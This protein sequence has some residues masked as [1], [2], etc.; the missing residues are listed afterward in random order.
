MMHLLKYTNLSF[1]IPGMIGKHHLSIR[2]ATAL[3]TC[4][5]LHL[6]LSPTASA[7]V[8]EKPI[9]RI[10]VGQHTAMIN[11]LAV[12]RA[13][14]LLA[15][16]SDDKTVRLWN[17]PEG[18]LYTT[19]RV[20][21]GDD[22]K[23]ALYAAAVSPDGKTVITAGETIDADQKFSLYVFDV[24]KRVLKARIPGL[25]SAIYHLAYSKDGKYFAAA[26]AGG[27]GI[28][29][30]DSQTGK[31]VGKDTDY[32][33]RSN[34]LAFS[35]S[36][37]LASVSHDGYLRLYD[38][39]F[40]LLKKSRLNPNGLPSSVAF[41]ANGQR[42]A[43][44]YSNLL[45]VD[46]IDLNLNQQASLVSD[47]LLGSNSAI[48]A[49]EHGSDTEL[50]AAGDMKTTA[51]RFVIRHWK[52]IDSGHPTKQDIEAGSNIVTDMVSLPQNDEQALTLFAS[53][54]PA[55]GILKQD[56]VMES[57]RAKLWD[58]RLLGLPEK[59]FLL[60]EDG[61]QV[62]YSQQV[63]SEQ[64]SLFDLH[65]LALQ[66]PTDKA[67]TQSLKPAKS[68]AT[69]IT[70]KNWRLDVPVVNGKPV[71]LD[72][73]EKS[74]SLAINPVDDSALI[75][76][77]YYLRWFDPAG[78]ALRK[79]TMPAAVNALS[80]SQNGKLAVAALGDGTI[81]WYSL[82]P[83]EE[84][85]ELV[86]FF[87]Y[88]DGKEWIVWTPEG[89]F[90]SSDNGGYRLAG[91]HLNKGDNKRPEWIEFNQLYQSYYAPELIVPKLL[92]QEEKVTERLKT[93]G[94]IE[95]R[96]QHNET[97]IIEWLDY[98]VPPQQKS[99]KGFVRVT[100]AAT[101][102]ESGFM[103]KLR[104]FFQR[105]LQWLGELFNL[106]AS[107]PA[108]PAIVASTTESDQ[109]PVC[110]PI[111]GQGQ[112]RGFVRKEALQ[113]TV[114]RNQLAENAGTIEL[115]Y[116]IKPRSGGIGDVDIYLNGQIQNSRKQI[117]NPATDE[118]NQ[119]VKVS[120]T[121]TLKEG[122]NNISIHAYEKTGGSAAISESLALINPGL[123][124]TVSQ[125]ETA[126]AKSRLIVFSV[127]IDR[128]PSPNA[129]KYAVKDSS[130]FLATVQ[131]KKSRSYQEIIPIQ[132]FDEQ[133]TLE[134]IASKFDYIES[135]LD[136]NDTL[137]IYLSGHG[138]RE[139]NDFYFIPYAVDDEHLD[140]TALS[141]R[142]LKQTIARLS[143][144]NRIFIFIDSCHSGAVDLDSV[145]QEIASIDKI[146]H[147][148]GDNVFILAAA[149]A[150]QEAQDQWVQESNNSVNNG[151]FAHV[152]L[153]GLN[154][155]ARRLDDNI[156][157]NFTLGTYVQ[158]RIDAITQNQSRYKQ[159]ARFQLMEAG[160]ISSFDLTQYEDVN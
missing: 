106:G 140:K 97:P 150:D 116:S 93:I 109:A 83:G 146:K 70:I 60:S 69:R 98:C 107:V 105:L 38:A 112:T 29:V 53:A 6:T 75:G 131:A 128:Y 22:L 134:N 14:K 50:Y 58:S 52:A 17:L 119:N 13:G 86:T 141:Q 152:V 122:E 139:Q 71:K 110:Y 54:D 158:R 138:L 15:S 57:N 103:D 88:N 47:D 121:I 76:S 20:P 135:I 23:G 147:Q 3:F 96:L 26:F 48:V 85:N 87:P 68:D 137:L 102:V 1:L 45:R 35:E 136:K 133:A 19:L 31:T 92:R 81:R 84:L 33:E 73:Y 149:G 27:Y 72:D 94:S 5:I 120:Q 44:G 66:T 39:Q 143:K 40:A 101:P 114:Y 36:G 127:G 145:Q 4:L 95:D 34:W 100:N 148:L 51:G 43:V 37:Q 65:R 126:G 30:W 155:K 153:E 77:N 9:L 42:L 123:N 99:T 156:V 16:A 59:S 79:I 113:N 24:E 67:S 151:L 130:D 46:V 21:I 55:W 10:D 89:F 82:A 111:S 2:H 61:L 11:R 64:I 28:Q 154:G 157:D 80:I 8:Q 159:K 62:A 41:S 7:Q 12:D 56:S 124:R 144:T 118:V 125:Q 160:D 90:A 18:T 25:P 91:Y 108:S 104:Q 49:W 74:L 132:L 115:H 32:S 63:D 142:M 78:K 117:S 129:L